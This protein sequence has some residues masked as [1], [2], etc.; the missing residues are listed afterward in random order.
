[1]P[2]CYAKKRSTKKMA[3]VH[4]QKGKPFWFCSYSTYSAE[5]SKWQRHFKSTKLTNKKAA[6]E[7]CRAW[8]QTAKVGRAGKLTP[9]TA[10]EIVARG[11]ADIFTAV[12]SETMPNASLRAWCR[13]WLDAKLIEAEPSTVQRYTYAV[14]QFLAFLG[15]KAE[16]DIA[17]VRSADVARFRDEQARV[18]SR[19]TA[20]LGVKVLRAC[21]NQAFK[22][23]LLTSNPA[24]VVDILKQRGECK[25]RAFT[26]AELR[27][28]LDAAK[29]SDWYGATLTSLYPGA[30]L[31]D[32]ARLTW[33]A[34]DLQQNT[35]AF[36]AKKTGKRMLVPLAKPLAEHLASLPSTDDPNAP[37][38][39]SLAKLRVSQ[40]SDGFRSVLVDAGL[41]EER[42]HEATGKGRN[43]SRPVAELSF[44]SLRH[45]FVSILK[46]TGAN[47]AVAMALAGHET[48]AVSQNYTHLD[49]ATLRGAM[50]K[51]T[52]VTK[53]AK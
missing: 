53:A 37:V 43:V 25:R 45:S 20:N 46:N 48:K 15:T 50:D 52:D 36:V 51:M 39:P 2:Y 49:T 35:V 26:L 13:Q 8:E 4:K 29:G 22:Q 7:V 40:L 44:H 18:L 41:A 10:R 27:R 17:S 5:N 14:D 6:W 23:G 16:R 34:V 31:S 24:K 47:E 3:S 21:F 12:N 42:S 9:E 1:M 19:N 38:F 30:R 28:V 11:V 33:R 32:M